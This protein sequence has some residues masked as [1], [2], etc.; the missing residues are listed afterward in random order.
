MAP[1]QPLGNDRSATVPLE[2]DHQI[3]PHFNEQVDHLN[4]LVKLNSLNLTKMLNLFN[5]IKIFN[6]INLITFL[7]Q[8]AVHSRP[9]WSR[10][11]R[12]DGYLDTPLGVDNVPVIT[13]IPLSPGPLLLDP[14]TRSYPPV[15]LRPYG[16][17]WLPP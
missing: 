15:P 7:G 8:A 13:N 6:L 9:C 1:L 4:H 12:G 11:A 14:H 2:D 17:P 5:S 16:A 10:S 3:L